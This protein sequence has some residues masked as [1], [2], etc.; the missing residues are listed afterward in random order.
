MKAQ[1][2]LKKQGIIHLDVESRCDMYG[3]TNTCQH[4]KI[5]LRHLELF[6]P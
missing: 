5:M 2:V 4:C 3:F 6:Y 1:F